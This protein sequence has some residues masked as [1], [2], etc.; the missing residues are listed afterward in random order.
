N[1]PVRFSVAAGSAQVFG[2]AATIPQ[3]SAEIRTDANGFA[4]ATALLGSVPQENNLIQAGAGGVSVTF[5]ETSLAG[6]KAKI[7]AGDFHALNLDTAGVVW[8]WGDNSSGQLG[9]GTQNP[10]NTPQEI[11]SLGAVADLDGGNSHSVFVGFDGSVWTCGSNSEGQLG[12]GTTNDR[13]LPA[14]VPDFSGAIA[15]GAGAYHTIAL[16]ADGTVWAWGYNDDGEMGDGTTSRRLSP[17]QVMIADGVPLTDVIAISAGQYH[18]LAL[19][20]DGTVCSWGYNSDG[21]LGDGTRTNS[22]FAKQIPALNQ[23]H[24]IRAG[25]FHSIAIQH[26]APAPPAFNRTIRIERPNKPDQLPNQARN[27]QSDSLPSHVTA[28]ATSDSLWMW[29]DNSRG[30]LGDGTTV[31]KLTPVPGSTTDVVNAVAAGSEHTLLVRAD[32]TVVGFGRNNE[33]QANGNPAVSG[34]QPAEVQGASGIVDATGGNSFSLALASN[35]LIY[36]WGANGAGQLGLGNYKSQSAPAANAKDS[37]GSGM[38]DGWQIEHFGH[39][40]VDGSADD[41]GDGLTNAQEYGVGS[42]PMNGDSDGDGFADGVDGWVLDGDLHPPRLPE[43][44]YVVIDLG[45]GY[46]PSI[47]NNNEV[48]VGGGPTGAFIWKDGQRQELPARSGGFW[49]VAINDS[50]HALLNG[51]P[52]VVWTNGAY[53]ELR[54]SDDPQDDR[55]IYWDPNITYHRVLSFWLNGFNNAGACAGDA[56]ITSSHTPERVRSVVWPAA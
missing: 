44:R 42:D 45:E 34:S 16:R 40:G 27:S 26:H 46:S 1:A 43:Y 31:D 30:Q 22:R 37:A 53:T 54:V 47:N 20:G 11:R 25:G 13:Y 2:D 14:P 3:T 9:D 52:A 17:V 4:S 6:P 15:V 28:D 5:T 7:V 18:N 49:P 33:G 32:G 8:A 48:L 23:V 10:R 39:T 56:L 35:G 21:Q 36:G 24:S 12:D 51:S 55:K 50:G 19:K 29:G 41:D 38:P